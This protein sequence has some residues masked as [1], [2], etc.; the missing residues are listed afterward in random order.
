MAGLDAQDTQDRA[1]EALGR[2]EVRDG[3]ADVIEYPAQATDAGM[4]A[5]GTTP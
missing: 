5:A 2:R 1:V 4:V 3:D